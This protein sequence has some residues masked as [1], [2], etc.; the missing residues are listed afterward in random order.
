MRW[1]VFI[2]LAG[3]IREFPKS[4]ISKMGEFVR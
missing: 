3:D 1:G 4:E 2:F